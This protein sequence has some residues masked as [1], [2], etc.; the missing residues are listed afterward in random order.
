MFYLLELIRIKLMFL[1]QTLLCINM[2]T[3][4][5]KLK[6]IKDGIKTEQCEIC[7]LIEW[8]GQKIP[9]ELHHID[10]NRHN[11]K[12]NN[13]KFLCPNC[14]SQ[15]HTFCGGNKHKYKTN[16]KNNKAMDCECQI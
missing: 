3:Y 8:N 16:E 7:K 6:L 14:H 10:G 12:L 2:G 9:L 15:T 11:N 13:L 4:K 5:L 1:L